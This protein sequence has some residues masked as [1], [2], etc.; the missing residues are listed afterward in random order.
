[1]ENK[2]DVA[3]IDEIAPG[4]WKIVTVKG[5]EIGIY[6]RSGTYYGIRNVCPHQQA[7]LCLGV[8][9]GTNLPSKPHEYI[10]GMEE[11]VL[12]C[13]WHGWEFSLETG[14]SLFDPERYK[15]KTYPVK[16]EN[17]RVVLYV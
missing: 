9:S 10:F 7:E 11:G 17:E 8:V 15:V 4:K 13:P 14:K 5:R 2:Y 16:V 1:M 6:N 3:G 12:S